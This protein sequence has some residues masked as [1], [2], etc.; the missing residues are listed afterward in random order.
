[1][2]VLNW[3]TLKK[4][5]IFPCYSRPFCKFLKNNNLYYIKKEYDKKAK[6]YFFVFLRT[7]KFN[8]LLNEWRNN[9]LSGTFA[10]PKREGG[11]VVE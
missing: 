7:V 2:N 9:K 4:E 5:D 3:K 11:E 6:K 10:F 1:M 8:D